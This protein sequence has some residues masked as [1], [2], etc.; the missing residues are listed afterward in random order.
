MM[1]PRNSTHRFYTNVQKHIPNPLIMLTRSKHN[2][3]GVTSVVGM[4]ALLEK[5]MLSSQAALT[6]ICMVD[7]DAICEQQLHKI[8]KDSPHQ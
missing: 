7:A 3:T 5:N 8:E 2:N 4:D 1:K 6:H